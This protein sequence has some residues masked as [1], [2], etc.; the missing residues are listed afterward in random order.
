MSEPIEL[1]ERAKSCVGRCNF[2]FYPTQM[3]REV[4][5][6]GENKLEIEKTIEGILLCT[7]CAFAKDILF[8]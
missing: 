6:E 1:E 2:V 4:K 8:K 5:V 3:N 7:S